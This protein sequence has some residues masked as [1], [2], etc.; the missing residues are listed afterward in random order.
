MTFVPGYDQDVFISCAH[1]D[2]EP[3][4]DE[5][6]GW[7]ATFVRL[8]R[9]ELAQKV[10]RADGFELW[11]DAISLRGNH[12]VTPELTAILRR[13]ATFVAIL[14]PPYAASRWCR[15][16][17]AEEGDPGAQDVLV[18]DDAKALPLY[19]QAAGG[20]YAPAFSE[21]GRAYWDGA[22]GYALEAAVAC[23][24]RGSLARAVAAVRI[25]HQAADW[26]PKAS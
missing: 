3:F 12:N 2:N 16:E 24:R 15:D 1:A 6:T 21:V 25:A 9:N 5:P 11:F 23:A 4:L 8:L 26:R 13:A 10:G 7:V 14:S 19:R 18:K 17:A 20:G 22:A